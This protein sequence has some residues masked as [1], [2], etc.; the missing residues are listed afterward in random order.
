MGEEKK[1]KGIIPPVITVFN[2]KGDIDGEK[3]KTFITSLI[4]QGV[5]GIFVGGSTGEASL[6]S[7]EQRKEI[8]DI[9]VEATRGKVPLMAGTGYNSTRITVELSRYAESAGADAVV[10]ALPHYPKPTQEGLYEHYKAIGEAVNIPVFIYNWPQQYGL[11]IDLDV[12]AQLATEGH[13]GGIKDSNDNLDWAA[14]TL[15]MTGGSIAV[16]TGQDPKVFSALCLGM[17][18]AIIATGNMLPKLFVEIYD[19]VNAGKIKEAAEKQLNLFMLLPAFVERQD[20]A[21]V[22]EGLRMMG[23]DVGEALMPQ[24]PVSEDIKEKL[25]L[26]LTMLGMI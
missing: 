14:A 18:G 1:F 20:M 6:M 17:D 21:V 25:K 4:D 9:G 2:A 10:A 26:S 7:M 19:L 15:L 22:K 12:I 5:H 24:V 8:I 23:H 13:I 3:T 16:F 11:S